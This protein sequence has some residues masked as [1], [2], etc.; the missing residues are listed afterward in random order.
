MPCDDFELVPRM[1]I[2]LIDIHAER[3]ELAVAGARNQRRFFFTE[4]VVEKDA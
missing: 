4:G 3:K 1:S 2:V